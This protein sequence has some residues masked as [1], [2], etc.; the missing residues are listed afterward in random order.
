MYFTKKC[1][2]DP[3]FITPLI[4]LLLNKRRKLRRQGQVDDANIVAERINNLISEVNKN[5]LSNLT[6]ASPKE[7][8]RAVKDISGTDR[9]NSKSALLHPLLKD[10]DTVNAF[11][12]ISPVI[13]TTTVMLLMHLVSIQHL[14]TY[15]LTMRWSILRRVTRTTSGF[16]SLP[17]WRFQQCFYELADVV[18]G[19]LNCSFS[20][21]TLP[22]QR[23]TAVIS[24]A[25]KVASPDVLSHY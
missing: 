14:I 11:L 6:D 21:S 3:P 2:S 23:L 5:S 12:P 22:S 24:L 8:W 15:C 10:T 13:R 20:T 4:K 17:A 18:T 7:L 19:I 16:D 25:P 1:N 9:S